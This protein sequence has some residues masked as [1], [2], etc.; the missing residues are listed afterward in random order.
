MEDEEEQTPD[1]A[2]LIEKLND[3]DGRLVA[4]RKRLDE[5]AEAI[6]FWKMIGRNFEETEK[7][8]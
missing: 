1:I 4:N 8:E 7:D 3:V 2:S 6:E 5:L